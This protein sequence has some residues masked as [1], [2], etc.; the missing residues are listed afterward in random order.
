MQLHPAILSLLL[1]PALAS[2]PRAGDAPQV[3]VGSTELTLHDSAVHQD[4]FYL[5]NDRALSERIACLLGDV[6]RL[7][8]GLHALPPEWAGSELATKP[9]SGELKQ[10]VDLALA[11]SPEL[12]SMRSELAVLAAK[13]RQAGAR[14]DPMLSVMVMDFPAPEFPPETTWDDA[15][16]AKWSIG[17]SQTFEGY[18]KRDLKRGIAHLDELMK[19]L[20]LAEMERKVVGE[21]TDK[22]FELADAKA[23]LRVMDTNIEL[24][25]LLVDL[26]EQKYGL[27]LTPQAAVLSAQV[28]LTRMERERLDMRKMLDED[29]AML[30]GML[31]TPPGFDPAALQLTL[32]YPLPTDLHLDEAA[33][34]QAGLARL[35]GYQKLRLQQTQQGL[36]LEMARREYRPDYTITAGYQISW[37]ERDMLTAGVMVPLQ[38]NKAENQD[39]KVQEAYAMQAM[40]ADEMRDQENKLATDIATQS[41]DLQRRREL[42]ELSRT[43]LVPQARLA[44]DSNI[45]GYSANKMDLT[46]LLMAQQALLDAELELERG[47]IA[48]LRALAALQVATAGA[49]DPTPYLSPS[50]HLDVPAVSVPAQEPAEPRTATPFVDALN[51][52]QTGE[53]PG[54]SEAA[55]AGPGGKQD[56]FYAPFAP[57]RDKKDGDGDKQQ[58]RS[59]G[60]QR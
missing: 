7:L 51:L 44:L 25:Q 6:D 50:L 41:V 21:V 26:G 34:G 14:M 5:K 22:Y 55:P 3:V 56:D 9:V 36:M 49:F 60:D 23:Q 33:L 38:L 2:S 32:D 8:A 35:P 48:Y 54:T 19:E 15:V 31:G 47:Y 18:G 13:T 24:M 30:T 1:L 37:K 42:I 17:L 53:T 57:R 59:N 43:G 52:P 20:D 10:L 11:S 46:D 27:G 12:K 29:L 58:T 4:K 16:M 45:A 40:T 28:A 39:A